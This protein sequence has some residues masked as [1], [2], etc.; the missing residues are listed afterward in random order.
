ME[1]IKYKIYG[2]KNRYE[3]LLN[4][5]ESKELEK[6]KEL[7]TD[8]VFRFKNQDYTIEYD[9]NE[10]RAFKKYDQ[11][12][13]SDYNNEIGERY[14]HIIHLYD[15]GHHPGCKF[16]LGIDLKDYKIYE[17]DLPKVKNVSL[18]HDGADSAEYYR[19]YN[20]VDKFISMIKPEDFTLLEEEIKR[21]EKKISDSERAYEGKI[22]LLP[23]R[24]DKILYSLDDILNEFE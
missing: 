19:L 22:C 21:W 9:G 4:V 5:I 15:N 3:E 18:H 7:E 24:T 1:E 6:L 8:F 23:F 17:R 10:I 13:F 16:E 12:I 2:L 20:D 14:K 11:Y